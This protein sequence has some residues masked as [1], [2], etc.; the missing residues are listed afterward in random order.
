MALLKKEWYPD[1]VTCLQVYH[2]SK[3]SYFGAINGVEVAWG[4]SEEE[5]KNNLQIYYEENY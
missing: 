1:G 4:S 3:F 5:C 2:E